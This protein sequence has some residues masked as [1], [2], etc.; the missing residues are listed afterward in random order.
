MERWRWVSPTLFGL[1]VLAVWEIAGRLSGISSIIL[2]LPSE[3]FA[4]SFTD[5]LVYLR[6]GI[7]T[8]IEVLGGY[9]FAVLLG[10]LC[11]L[12]IAFSK[13]LGNA[14]YPALV[15]SQIMPKVAITPLLVVWF[16]FGY[17][18]KVI[19]TALIAFFPI[20]INTVIGLNMTTRQSIHLF[21][22]MGATPLQTFLK[23]RLPAALPVYFGG[24]KVAAT[25]AVIGVVVAEFYSS[26]SGL[27]YLLLLQTS[28]SQTVNAFGAILYLTILGLVIFGLVVLIERLVVPAHMLKR[29]DE[30]TG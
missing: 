4:V 17:E 13:M 6:N 12:V 9:F 7:P 28:Q 25:L 3:V 5:A 19:M 20:V 30:T 27:G 21:R 15:A 16:G 29:N 1:F 2:P 23:L 10:S 24:L 22:S 11:G 26:D 18:P 14:V 8:L